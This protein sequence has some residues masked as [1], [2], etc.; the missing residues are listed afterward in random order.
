MNNL[1]YELHAL[2]PLWAP[3]LVPSVAGAGGL[4]MIV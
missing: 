2:K 4:T 1:L 3:L